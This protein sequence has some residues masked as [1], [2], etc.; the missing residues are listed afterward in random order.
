MKEKK[1]ADW[2]AI[3]A[4]DGLNS[5][6]EPSHLSR[7]AF[8]WQNGRNWPF[9]RQKAMHFIG[10]VLGVDVLEGALTPALSYGVLHA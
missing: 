2:R 9:D 10:G 6:G 5:G 1:Y 7:V 4:Y 8:T 3:G